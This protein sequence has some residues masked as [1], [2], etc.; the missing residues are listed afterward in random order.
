MKRALITVSMIFLLVISVIGTTAFAN[1]M[2]ESKKHNLKI[3]YDDKYVLDQMVNEGYDIIIEYNSEIL[4]RFDLT[5]DET[6][7][8]DSLSVPY[9]QVISYWSIEETE[10]QY[11]I[12]PVTV[13]KNEEIN[14]VDITF[15]TTNGGLINENILLP[16]IVKTVEEGTNLNDI[17]PEV[18][19]EENFY[20]DGWYTLEE[21]ENEVEID[22]EDREDIQEL[23]EE[24][25]T[26][27]EDIDD[28]DEDDDEDR[29]EELEEEIEELEGD[30]EEAKEEEQYETEI[31]EEY[32]KVTNIDNIVLDSNKEYIAVLYPDTNENRVDDRKEEI[33]ITVDF[34][35]DTEPHEET[36]HVGQPIN[37]SRPYH[38]DYIFIDWFLDNEFTERVGEKRTFAED[39]NI[40][41]QWKTAQEVVYESGEKLINEERISDKVEEYLNNRN[42]TIYEEQKEES[43]ERE[44]ELQKKYEEDS[45]NHTE[46]RYTLKNFNTEQTFL[47]KFYD[48]ESFLFSVALPY[49]RTLEILNGNDQ[50][51]KE[52][53]VRQNTSIDISEFINDSE[54]IQFDVK[55]ITENNAVTTKIYPIN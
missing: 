5:E 15:L 31:I 23:E 32:Q 42:A 18:E 34:G 9:N 3:V 25:E 29:I 21:I 16:S 36:I 33:N 2:E 45:V 27:R 28:L 7:T 26:R 19:S 52:Y 51:I 14:E 39:T 38:E 49:G 47:M 48:D 1:Q 50:K 55:T 46:K 8:I 13:E 43:R 41:A 22:L 24:I 40:Y 11:I 53:G 37:L 20:F 4:N 17:L 6:I 12:T 44:E 35:L 54:N 30:L 10:N